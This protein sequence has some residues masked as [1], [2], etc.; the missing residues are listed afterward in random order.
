MKMR[1]VSWP[2]VVFVAVLGGLLGFYISSLG[3]SQPAVDIT[4]CALLFGAIAAVG[5]ANT[6]RKKEEE[7]EALDKK[8]GQFGGYAFNESTITF[9]G[10][11]Q[12]LRGVTASV[13]TAGA[14]ARYADVAKIATAG[15]LFGRAGVFM[16]AT[17]PDKKVDDRELYLYVRGVRHHWVAQ[18]DPDRGELA[19]QFASNVN[20]ASQKLRPSPTSAPAQPPRPA[21]ARLSTAAPN[22]ITSQLKSLSELHAAGKLSDEEFRA[23]KAK[24]LGN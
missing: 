14:I 19:R 4:G 16:A 21:P 20:T 23:A 11:R 2:T 8:F 15:A 7:R 22:D 18:I 17:G 13:E 12:P 10:E 6:N 9:N 3:H 24:A 1:H 5:T